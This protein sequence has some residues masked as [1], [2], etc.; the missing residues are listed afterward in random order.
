MWKLFLSFLILSPSFVMA[1]TQDCPIE[2]REIDYCASTEWIEGPHW[3]RFSTLEVKYWKKADA[4][5]KLVNLP[6]DI[7]VYPW[8]IMPKAE[9]GGRSPIVTSV[10]EGHIK[11]ER[12][13]FGK[14]PGHWEVRW[15][16]EKAREKD[17]ALATLKVLLP[18]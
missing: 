1:N 5:K 7:V 18:E 3:G 13:Q 15:R 2:I 16:K 8:M 14:M 12:F 11:Y 17:Q 6:P 10:G 4:E 9:H